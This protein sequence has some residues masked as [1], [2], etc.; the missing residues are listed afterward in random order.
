MLAVNVPKAEI[1]CLFMSFVLSMIENDLYGGRV[2]KKDH[3]RSI[4]KSLVAEERRRQIGEMIQQAG[5]IT[6]AQIE[7]R[8]GVSS[9]T[10]RRDLAVLEAEG[11]VRRTHGGAV[12][13]SSA[14]HED[15]FQVRLGVAVEEKQ[16]LGRAAVSL[17]TPD[18]TIF[19]DSSTTGY[20]LVKHLLETGLRAN[21]LTN[22]LPVMELVS[23]AEAPGIE[24]VGMGGT[25][26]R[27]TLSFVGPHTE[28]TVLEHFADKAF[29]SVKGVTRGGHLTDPNSLEAEVKRSMI[30]RAEYPVLLI[31]GHKF[32]RHGASVI[33]HVSDF[34]LAL[35]AG[36]AGEDVRAMEQQGIEVRSV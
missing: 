24:L 35:V 14:R 25:L 31:D 30:L 15:S 33:S 1:P 7:E 20:Y 29:I 32:E 6:V 11:R 2:G 8:F 22:S 26:R 16:K 3:K 17:L 19:V 23:E 28:R 4:N 27:L 9:I 21:I 18:E 13:P 10:V 36:A 34:S 5:S 12:L